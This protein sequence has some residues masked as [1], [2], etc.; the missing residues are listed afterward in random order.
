[1]SR[2]ALLSMYLCAIFVIAFGSP[3]PLNAAA[4]L[5]KRSYKSTVSI[6]LLI[7]IDWRLTARPIGHIL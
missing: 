4:E 5:T 2:L 3:L 7:L 6:V 1:M